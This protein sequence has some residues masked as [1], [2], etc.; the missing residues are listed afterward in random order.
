VWPGTHLSLSFLSPEVEM[1]PS[2][3]GLPSCALPCTYT[4]AHLGKGE[5]LLCLS[6]NQSLGC[7]GSELTAEA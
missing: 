7:G 6:G 2:L 1:Q 5:P 3:G 4:H